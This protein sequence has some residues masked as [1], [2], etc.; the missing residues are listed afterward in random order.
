MINALLRPS[1]LALA[2]CVALF[3]GCSETTS[4]SASEITSDVR[5]S[6]STDEVVLYSS[7]DDYVLRELI[8]AFEEE[9]GVKVRVVG[10]TEATKTTGLVERLLTERES[11]TA[12][13]W[14]SSEA[15][16]TIKLARAGALA[17]FEPA[18]AE[19]F[20]DGWPEG[21]VGEDRLWHGFGQRARAIAFHSD[22]LDETS[23]PATHEA[24][25]EEVW[26][27]RVGIAKPQFG[28]TR[29]HMGALLDIWGAERFEAWLIAMKANGARVY[30]GNATVVRAIRNGEIDVGLTD[31]DDVYHAQRNGWPIGMAIP[32]HD[33]ADEPGALLMPNTAALVANPD[34]PDAART[35]LDWILS[36]RCEAILAASDSRNF[37]I[38]PSVQA[39]HPELRVGAPWRPDL[40][41]VADAVPEAIEICG[42]VFGL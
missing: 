1:S 11:P 21:L 14:W 36:P 33:G 6:A 34:T 37:P 25:T 27:G 32:A 38:F 22:V 15:F 28:T 39:E 29:G 19:L 8:A 42:R 10:D 23:I 30:D 31:T 35:L 40:G 5:A 17:P 2:F 20:E 4:E 18:N 41:V 24:L 9:T 26:R 16:G 12:H 7:V 3:A 13:V